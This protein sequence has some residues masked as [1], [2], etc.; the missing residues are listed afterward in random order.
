MNEYKAL[1]L[2]VGFLMLV[3]IAGLAWNKYRQNLKRRFRIVNYHDSSD[4]GNHPDKAKAPT[5]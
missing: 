1:A 3:Y 5:S 4:S 2:Y